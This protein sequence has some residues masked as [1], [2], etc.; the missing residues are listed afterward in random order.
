MSN[1]QLEF[2]R[3]NAMAGFTRNSFTPQLPL[4]LTALRR[5]SRN[6]VRSGRHPFPARGANQ[7]TATG[8]ATLRS[9]RC[10]G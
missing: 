1:G 7:S 9:A 8:N 5:S 6:A 3:H 4:S 10:F 2:L